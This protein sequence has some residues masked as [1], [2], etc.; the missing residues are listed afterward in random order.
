M[1]L[2]A[3]VD[4]KHVGSIYYL[5]SWASAP[6]GD[7]G[8]YVTLRGYSGSSQSSALAYYN[9]SSGGQ[10]EHNS[11]IGILGGTGAYS[12][13]SYTVFQTMVNNTTSGSYYLIW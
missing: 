2:V 3:R 1:P 12:N 7:Y 8:H 13:K 4:P 5:T 11:S 10:D 9:D 6:A